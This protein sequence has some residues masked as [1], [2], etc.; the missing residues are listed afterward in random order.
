MTAEPAFGPGTPAAETA[1]AKPA[2]TKSATGTTGTESAVTEAT[3]GTTASESTVPEPVTGT[4][5]AEAAAVIPE[6]S[7][8]VRTAAETAFAG[9]AET[10]VGTRADMPSEPAE[11]RPGPVPELSE[12][13]E[14]AGLTESSA[15]VGR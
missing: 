2:L 11:I 9:P 7:E 8:V 14:L 12:A 1:V 10:T 4:A 5:A 3:P 13:A 6:P 15:H